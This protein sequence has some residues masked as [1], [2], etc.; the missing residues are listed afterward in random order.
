MT[1]VLISGAN[2][3]IGLAMVRRLVTRGDEV[4][5]LCRDPARATDLTNLSKSSA[6]LTVLSVDVTDE[7]ALSEAAV[8]LRGSS[9]DVVVCNAGVMSERGGIDSPGNTAADWQRVLAVNV[10]GAFL[11]ARTFLPA[12]RKAPAGKLAFISSMMASSALAAGGT[13]GYRAS[14]AAVANL[15]ANLAAELKPAGIAVGIY[16]PGWVST[17]M[18]GPTA[19]VTPDASAAGLIERFD[20]LSLRTTGVFEDYLGK[21]YVF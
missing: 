10:I 6:R 12:L 8:S 3:G 9:L 13:L 19:P 2:R 17:G 21:P 4:V 11:T 14:K 1:R 16:H 15:G 20:R 7:R 18:G 5:A